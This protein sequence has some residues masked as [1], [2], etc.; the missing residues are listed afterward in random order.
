MGLT[1]SSFS[2]G[3]VHCAAAQLAAAQKFSLSI[4]VCVC[5]GNLLGSVAKFS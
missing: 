2:L 4:C 3:L 1:E 5:A